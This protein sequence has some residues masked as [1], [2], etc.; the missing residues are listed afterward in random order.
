MYTEAKLGF[1]P[2][3]IKQKKT[4]DKKIE[5]FEKTKYIQMIW[6]SFEAKR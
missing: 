2:L 5:K 1:G 6:A 3:G 4:K